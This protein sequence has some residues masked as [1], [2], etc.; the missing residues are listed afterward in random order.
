MSDGEAIRTEAELDDRLSEPTPE[1]VAALGR[2]PG[3]IIVLGVAGKMGPTLARMARRASDAAGVRRR[4]IGVARFAAD[5][6]PDLHAHGVET[7]RCDLLDAAAVAHLPDASNVVFLAGR[8]FGCTGDEAATWATN[9]FLPGLVCE[10]YRQSRIVA[11]STGNVYGLV[12]VAGPG[13]REDDP[14]N[15]VGEYAMSC[16]GRERMFAYFSGRN[17]TPV[18]LVRLNYACDLRYGVLVDLAR[19]VWD[20]EPIDLAMSHFNTIWQGDAN[21]MVLRAFE[22]AA[23]PPFVVNV[24]GPEALSVRDVAERFGRLM[25]RPVRLTG[26][27]GKTALLSDARRGLAVLGAPRVGAGQL[28]EWVADWVMRGGRNLDKPTHF[29]ARDGRF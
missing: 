10:R 6:E 23:S 14:P 18:V 5:G 4:V 20:G 15:P 8:K 21:A 24:T 19:K 25:G 29:E 17:G 12:P 7:V 11:L 1:V 13:S 27:D 16:L 2:L 28:V 26:T 22:H 3:D 9:A